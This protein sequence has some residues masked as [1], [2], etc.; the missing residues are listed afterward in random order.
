[1][2]QFMHQYLTAFTGK[3]EVDMNAAVRDV[4]AEEERLRKETLTL[5]EV[6][7]TYAL[8]RQEELTGWTEAAEERGFAV[9]KV[10]SPKDK[11]KSLAAWL[12]LL[13]GT[14]VDVAGNG[15]CGWL[16]YYAALYNK[17]EGIAGPSAEV[18]L[19]ANLLKKR[20][21]NEMLANLIDEAQL[22]PDD[23]RAEAE[24]CGC[25]PGNAQS[26]IER[27]RVVA[28]H[29]VEQRAK[30]VRATVQM[31]YW[32]RPMH[33]KAMA[34]HARETIYVLDVQETETARLQA[35]GY[36]EIQDASGD[37]IATGTVCP[38]PT[39]QATALLTDLVQAGIR[40]PV[41]ILRW[42][43]AGNHFQAVH[44]EASEHDNYAKNIAMYAGVRNRILAEHG[45]KE[46]D[47]IEYDLVKSAHAAK[48]TL[49]KV[50][51]QAKA[52]QLA[53][54]MA[55]QKRCGGREGLVQQKIGGREEIPPAEAKPADGITR[56]EGAGS[57]GTT[58][59]AGCQLIRHSSANDEAVTAEA[60][61][62][63]GSTQLLDTASTSKEEVEVTAESKKQG[64]ETEMRRADDRS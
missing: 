43:P 16:A 61:E 36:H 4:K 13:Q 54:E 49:S 7:Q 12:E 25:G 9:V 27:V 29:L 53:D 33:L 32:V 34:C 26:D 10:T 15:H 35:Y 11:G 38:V 40:P 6:E 47:S 55:E 63:A 50:R 17:M 62:Q 30:S 2:Q 46:M 24:A 59:D 20:V 21:L 52:T 1:M 37:W 22:H 44:Y 19:N 51:R 48:D 8:H 45:W 57:E 39:E 31:H 58:G 64:S 56:S 23:M 28:N 42:G 60:G 3:T 41:M 14:E 5:L 18:V